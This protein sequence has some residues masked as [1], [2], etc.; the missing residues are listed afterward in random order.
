[1][2]PQSLQDMSI[3]DAGDFIFAPFVS[4]AGGDSGDLFLI[5]ENAIKQFI[6]E[7]GGG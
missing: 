3:L 7:S 5:S 4:D 1:M 2:K 6:T